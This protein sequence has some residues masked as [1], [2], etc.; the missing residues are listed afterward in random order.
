MTN[1]VQER[2]IEAINGN[3]DLAALFTDLVNSRRSNA[4]LTGQSIYIL[5]L[6][7][8]AARDSGCDVTP[9]NPALTEFMGSSFNKILFELTRSINADVE[10]VCKQLSAI[11]SAIN[12]ARNAG[13]VFSMAIKPVASMPVYISGMV[14]R[15]TTTEVH[16]DPK[17]LEITGSVQVEK[18]I[19]Q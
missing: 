18:D 15:V 17:S 13:N 16:R 1:F 12:N 14:G 5:A 11:V 8:V 7:Y 10:L 2:V 3:E 19:V 6:V 4:T 9:C